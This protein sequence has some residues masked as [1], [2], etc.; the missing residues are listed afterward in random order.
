M[1]AVIGLLLLVGAIWSTSRVRPRH[2]EPA[3][4]FLRRESLAVL[5]ALVVT[6]CM[7]IG[8]ALLVSG[9]VDLMTGTDT[10]ATTQE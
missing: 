1:T 8:T 7:G 6:S 4:A 3:A 10:A 9:T 5:F 2:G